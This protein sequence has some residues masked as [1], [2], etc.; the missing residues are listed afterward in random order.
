MNKIG[1]VYMAT[2]VYKNYFDNFLNSLKFLFPEDNKTLIVISDGLFEYNEKV[3]DNIRIYVK[4][5]VDLPFPILTGFKLRFVTKYTQNFNFDYIMYFDSD[6]IIFEKSIEFWENLKNKMN[7]GKLL[8]TLHPHYLYYPNLN[9]YD[10]FIV[11]N[12]KSEA[13][14]ELDDINSKKCYIMSSFI[15]GTYDIIKYFDEKVYNMAEKDIGKLRWMPQ[16]PDEAYLNKL[17]LYYDNDKVIL[18]KYATINPY[19]FDFGYDVQEL[20]TN[21]L[22]ENNFSEYDDT[23]FINQ[24]YDIELKNSKKQYE[25]M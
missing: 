7:T 19:A 18:E 3:I 10:P 22:Y 9:F 16:Y 4:D 13:F 15:G 5:V 1:I 8:M 24:K 25:F 12:K 21:N 20:T 17:Y 2:S 23:I 14:I 6:T 11:Y